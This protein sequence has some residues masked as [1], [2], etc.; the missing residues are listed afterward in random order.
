LLVRSYWVT[1]K[2]NTLIT[3]SS[4]NYG[5]NQFPEKA[6]P[7]FV[8]QLVEGKKIPIYG[9]GENIRDWIFVD[10]HCT[11]IYLV[12]TKGTPGEIYNIGG[13]HELSNNE[14]AMKIINFLG[15]DESSLLY[16]ADRPGHDQ[17]YS[18]NWEKIK[19][20]GYSPDGLFDH[21]LEKVLSHYVERFN[22]IEGSSPKQSY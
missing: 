11:G 19:L 4:N 13:G 16:I 18:V 1:H 7:F 6:I 15:K 5:V 12:L 2:L 8:K 10:D 14:L 22:G 3:R 17:R 20:L 21:H 9:N